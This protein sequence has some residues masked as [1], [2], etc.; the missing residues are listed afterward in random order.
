MLVEGQYIGELPLDPF[1][2]GPPVYRRTDDAFILYSLGLNFADDGGEPGLGRTG[3]SDL[4]ARG[5]D[6]V[7]WPPAYVF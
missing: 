2:D 6:I 4:L 3:R 1:S 7:I 5:G